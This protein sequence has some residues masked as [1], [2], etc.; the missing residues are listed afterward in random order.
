[1]RLAATLILAF[2]LASAAAAP[3]RSADTLE[4][5]VNELA[6][7][8]VRNSRLNNATTIAVASFPHADNTC[9]ELSNYIVDELVLSLFLI[10][11]VGLQIIERAQ[12]QTILA[13][14]GLGLTGAIDANTTREIGR[15][16]GVDSLIIGSITVVGDRLRI[17]ARMIST[18][19]GTVFAAAAT[20]VPKT[21]TVM[22]LMERPAVGGCGLLAGGPNANGQAAGDGRGAAQ[23]PALGGEGFGARLTQDS[24]RLIVNDLLAGLRNKFNV[25]DGGLVEFRIENQTQ[26][27]L[28]LAFDQGR[29][30]AGTCHNVDNLI[31]PLPTYTTTLSNAPDLGRGWFV[32]V[33]GGYIT[34]TFRFVQGCSRIALGQR[35]TVSMTV[36]LAVSDGTEIVLFPLQLAEVPLRWP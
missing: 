2:G 24:L 35:A 32:L 26:M 33:P 14:L 13:E 20:T 16:H 25:E 31:G 29:T 9:S 19:T 10:P 7:E 12:L 18:E 3:A 36:I 28:G 17:I 5:G 15:I 27:H 4:L 30:I 34:G 8:I 1:M 11:E 22:A 21:D 6:R 23:R